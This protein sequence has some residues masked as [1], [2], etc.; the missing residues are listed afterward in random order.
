MF[1]SIHTGEEYGT[2]QEAFKHFCG[3]NICNGCPFDGFDIDH[4]EGNIIFCDEIV[5]K[6][7]EEA[8]QMIGIVKKDENFEDNFEF[9]EIAF[10]DMMGF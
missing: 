1:I 10:M 4:P 2:L 3:D 6:Y 7:P 5:D 8:M 9:D